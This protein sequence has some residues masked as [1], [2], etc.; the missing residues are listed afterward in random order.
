M[1]HPEKGSRIPQTD[2][3]GAR[4]YRAVPE[5]HLLASCQETSQSTVMRSARLRCRRTNQVTN[6]AECKGD[7]ENPRPQYL[8]PETCSLEL[9]HRAARTTRHVDRLAADVRGV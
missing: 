2:D 4:C 7:G 3:L 9:N 8:K 5:Q 6:R 1:M